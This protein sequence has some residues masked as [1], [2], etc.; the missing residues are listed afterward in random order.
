MG[1][2]NTLL[3]IQGDL[4]FYLKK[5]VFFFL[6]DK[7]FYMVGNEDVKRYEWGEAYAPLVGLKKISH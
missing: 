3:Y 6:G 2:D 4:A 5:F 7:I 1:G